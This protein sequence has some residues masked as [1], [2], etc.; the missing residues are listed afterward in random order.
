GVGDIVQDVED[1]GAA[2]AFG[3]VDA[4]VLMAAMLAQLAGAC[5]GEY[6][7]V[8][9]A[10]E[11]KAAGGAGF[12]AGGVEALGGAVGAQGGLVHLLRG[13]V[14]LGNVEGTAGDAVLA[15][16][17]V[18]LLKIDDAVLVLDNGSVSGAGDEAAGFGAVHALVLAHEP[19]QGAVFVGVLAELDEVPV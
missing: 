14:E 8:F 6:R 5:L 19:L 3:I 12:D 7:H 1:A 17:A 9:L 18:F 13:G 15:A 4:G 16:D 10:A 2:D 11:V